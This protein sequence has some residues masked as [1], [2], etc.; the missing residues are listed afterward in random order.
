M[1]CGTVVQKHRLGVTV[2]ERP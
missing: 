2:T 1:F